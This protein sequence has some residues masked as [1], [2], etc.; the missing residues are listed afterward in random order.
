MTNAELRGNFACCRNTGSWSG[1][2]QTKG[3]ITQRGRRC[4][5][6]V[7]MKKVKPTIFRCRVF[8]LL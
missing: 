4:H 6:T 5:A 2:R 8:K 7:G 3:T 1:Q